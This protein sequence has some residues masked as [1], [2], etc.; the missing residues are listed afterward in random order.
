[1]SQDH[2]GLYRVIA[3]HLD[4]SGTAVERLVFVCDRLIFAAGA[5]T[6]RMLLTARET[7]ALP[8]LHESIGE[9]WGSNG[10]HLTMIRTSLTPVGAPQ[11]GPS[12]VLVRNSDGTAS[13]M[14]SPMPFPVGSGL[15]TCLGMG[16][17]DHFGHWTMT[18]DNRT[19][20]NW[21]AEYDA[22]SR[23]AVDDFVVDADQ[24]GAGEPVG[25]R[26]G[27]ASVVDLEDLQRQAIE[28]LEAGKDTRCI[29]GNRCGECAVF[30][31]RRPEQLL[32]NDLSETLDGIHRGA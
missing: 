5:H 17:S 7:G 25:H 13:V 3:E 16:I 15:L 2:K 28:F 31:R 8:H 21:K 4:E 24:N 26:G 10:D 1:M 22:T 23:N 19:E 29:S 18:A 14:H 6:P 27:G 9:G 20:L 12:A 30:V 32:L 11:G